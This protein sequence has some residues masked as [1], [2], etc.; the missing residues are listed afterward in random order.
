[1]L[2][3]YRVIFLAVYL[4]RFL[5]RILIQ[6]YQGSCISGNLIGYPM[7]NSSPILVG[8]VDIRVNKISCAK[9]FFV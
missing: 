5:I 1:M 7:S 3:L 8:R 9:G 6:D 2:V 4:I